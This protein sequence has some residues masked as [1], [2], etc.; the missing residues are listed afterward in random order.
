MA[1]PIK[2]RTS[3]S[4]LRDVEILGRLRTALISDPNLPENAET[5]A[6]I[7]DI[8]AVVTRLVRL[9]RVCDAAVVAS[10]HATRSRVNA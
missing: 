7:R 4:Y 9:A 6:L 5:Q 2:A 3:K 1:A 8:D 10:A